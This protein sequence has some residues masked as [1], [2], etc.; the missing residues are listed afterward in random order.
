MKL[1]NFFAFLKP[2]SRKIAI[3]IVNYN[4]TER[5]DLL[6]SF[7]KENVNYP[8]D[9]YLIDNGSDLSSPS[10]NTNVFIKKNIQTT[11]GWLRGLEESDKKPYRYFAYMF[12]ITSAEFTNKSGDP[13]SSLAEVLEKQKDAVG[14]HPALSK[15]STTYWAHLKNRGTKKIR[16]TWFVDNISSLYRA[17]WFNSIGRF[18][19]ELI[20]AHGIDLETGYLARKQGKSIWID[21]RVEVKKVTDIGY[22][23]KRMNMSAEDRRK[24]AWENTVE[25][26]SKKY[27]PNWYR[28]LYEDYVQEE[29]K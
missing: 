17:N 24:L 3:F 21:E 22:K 26:F 29:W 8:L 20:Y 25:V 16:R 6:F 13:V 11:G 2:K 18:D 7:L 4:M 23:M 19:K 15:D 5:A 9:I 28:M 14:V 27:G 10:K 1:T 12:L